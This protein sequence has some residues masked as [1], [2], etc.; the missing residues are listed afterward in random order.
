LYAGAEAFCYPSLLEG[1]GLP[2]LEAMAQGTPV[3][4]SRGTATEEVLGP[5]GRSVDPTR[6]DEVSEALD[7]VM[8]RRAALSE[9]A[10]AQATRFPWSR[11]AE[12]LV[13]VYQ[14]VAGA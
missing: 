12:A 11:T 9:R 13:T 10:R 14:Q 6:P 4:T 8:R 1:F 3:V 5:G 7:E 2:V